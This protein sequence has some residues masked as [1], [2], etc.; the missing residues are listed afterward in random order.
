MYG[1]GVTDEGIELIKK[2]EGF[3]TK[4]YIDPVGKATIGY[5]TTAEAGIGVHPRKGMVISR[6]DAE[7][8]LHETLVIFANKVRPHIK[9]DISANEFSAFMSLVYNIGYPKFLR[10][11]ALRRF[12]EGDRKGA[13]NAILMWNKGTINGQKRV[14]TGLVLR[15]E[16]ER[17]L[18]LT[19]DADIEFVEPVTEDRY[20]WSRLVEAFLDMIFGEKVGKK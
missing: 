16:A 13:A 18:F 14:L 8:Y 19:P 2:F 5:G 6:A 17:R 20:I 9:R 10:S 11:T 15:R 3:R 1:H 12:N 4:T 7:R